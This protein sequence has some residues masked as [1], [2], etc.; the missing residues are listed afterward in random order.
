MT[1][2]RSIAFTPGIT[3]VD[4][5]FSI[6]FSSS[7]TLDNEDD[8][9]Y[10]T[11]ISGLVVRTNPYSERR[12]RAGKLRLFYVDLMKGM[13]D[14]ISA[15]D[16]LDTRSETVDFYTVLFDPRTDDFKRSIYQI[17]GEEIY[18]HNLLILD[19][20]EILP[21]Y[22]GRGLGLACLY[23]CMRQYWHGCGL[24]AIKC[25]PLQ[26]ELKEALPDKGWARRMEMGELGRGLAPCRE[27]L[28]SYYARLGFVRVGK[29]EFMILNPELRQ[30]DFESLDYRE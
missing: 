26:F 25:F 7:V 12:R 28:M 24:V 13:V 8:D 9:S 2:R 22:R 1:A 17:A 15:L 10:L 5:F 20:L 4:D 30:P 23:R 14:G 16:I 29:S 27:K 6:E 3:F 18:S 11:E 19:R 21:A